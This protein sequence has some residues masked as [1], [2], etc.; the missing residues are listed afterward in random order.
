MV[1]TILSHEV[2]DYEVW[3]KGFD[4]DAANRTAMGVKV[5]G[6]YRAADKPNMVTVITEVPSVEAIKAFIANPDLRAT[7]EKL[8]VI[9]APQVMIL[10]KVG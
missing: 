7:M 6:L 8:G 10:N 4:G 1:T 5:T 9:G 2:K 3:K